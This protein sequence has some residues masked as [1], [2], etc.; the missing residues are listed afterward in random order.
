M[1]TVSVLYF[2]GSGHT[3]KMAEAVAKGAAAGGAKVNLLAIRAEAQRKTIQH[4]D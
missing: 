3:A 2:S 4:K 1:T